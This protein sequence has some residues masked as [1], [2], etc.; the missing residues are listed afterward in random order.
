VVNNAKRR[1][2]LVM[3]WRPPQC[4]V[5]VEF[6]LIYTLKTLIKRPWFCRGHFTI[7]QYRLDRLLS[8]MQARLGLKALALAWPERASACRNLR[9]GPSPQALTGSMI[10]LAL[11]GSVRAWLSL[12]APRPVS[13]GNSI[14]E[15]DPGLS[16]FGKPEFSFF[17]VS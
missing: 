2:F 8:D 15:T 16:F 3:L 14:R 13:Q 11:P 17:D 6:A 5:K 9:P 10:G 7:T 4:E 1:S 12:L